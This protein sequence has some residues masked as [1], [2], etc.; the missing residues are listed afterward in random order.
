MVFEGEC[1]QKAAEKS[2]GAGGSKK[3]TSF[4]HKDLAKNPLKLDRLKK[5][6]EFRAV[7]KKAHPVE[8][9][10]FVLYAVSN[11]LGLNRIGISCSKAKIPLATKR[12]RI[13]RLIKE[14]MLK[15][16]PMLKKG[17]DLIFVVRKKNCTPDFKQVEE[18]IDKLLILKKLAK[19]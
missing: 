4:P 13:K 7:Y 16:N 17:L 3:D 18:N 2:L 5:P 6:F 14:V 19:I 10:I 11:D 15:K 8:S 1:R 9:A 12:N